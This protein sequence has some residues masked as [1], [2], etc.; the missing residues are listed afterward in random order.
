MV[1]HAVQGNRSSTNFTLL[2]EPSFHNLG[3]ALAPRIGTNI[4]VGRSGVFT[5]ALQLA[6]TTNRAVQT[7]QGVLLAVDASIAFTAGY[8][9]M[10]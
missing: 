9:V 3:L 4:L 10:W 5:P 1:L 8:T 7:P 6:Y 2:A